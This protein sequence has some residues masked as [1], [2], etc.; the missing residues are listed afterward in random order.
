MGLQNKPKLSKEAFDQLRTLIYAKCGISFSDAKKYLLESRLAKRIEARGLKTFEDYIYFLNYDAQKESEIVF[1]INTIVTN[2]TSFY[3]DP[4]QLKGFDQG[5]VPKLVE[6]KKKANNKRMKVWSAASS[7]GEE[8]YTLAMMLLE[9][10]LGNEGWSIEVTGSDISD[11]VLRSAKAATYEQYAIRNATPQQLARFFDQ[12]DKMYTVKQDVQR[13][14]RYKKI[15]LMN[16]FETRLIKD[17]DVIFCRNVLIYFDD[18][19]KKKAVANLYDSLAKGGYLFIGFSESLHDIT[20]L[21]KPVRFC[22][23]MVYQKI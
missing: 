10:G 18:A 23:T 21:F 4:V 2:E 20:R 16:S 5:V 17:N 14:V 15:N 11:N 12:K 19:S 1:L 3:R 22:G 6:E 7:T 9:L 8:P 13:L